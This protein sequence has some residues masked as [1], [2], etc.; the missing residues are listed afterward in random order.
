[1][2]NPL[3]PFHHFSDKWPKMDYFYLFGLYLNSKILNPYVGSSFEMVLV[4]FERDILPAGALRR[5]DFTELKSHFLKFSGFCIPARRT[6]C[7]F[8]PTLAVPLTTRLLQVCSV[9]CDPK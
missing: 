3:N 4:R 7:C 2:P 5:F 9:K 8:Y 1:M 6:P